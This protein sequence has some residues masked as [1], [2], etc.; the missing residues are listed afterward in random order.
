MKQRCGNC[1]FYKKSDQPGLA[2]PSGICRRYSPK[3]DIDRHDQW[4]PVRE[5]DW[6][7]EWSVKLNEN[8]DKK[9]GM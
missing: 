6:C 9:F 5:I 2:Y 3:G 1:K 8:H 7:G 4:P